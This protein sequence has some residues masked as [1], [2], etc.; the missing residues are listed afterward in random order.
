MTRFVRHIDSR[1]DKLQN[2]ELSYL[3]P[4]QNLQN[5]V[6][7]VLIMQEIYYINNHKINKQ[8]NETK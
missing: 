3:G 6:W 4:T 2:N 7:I 8:Y 5:D 1:I